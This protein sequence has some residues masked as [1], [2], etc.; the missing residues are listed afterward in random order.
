M[1]AL[2]EFIVRLLSP[3]PKKGEKLVMPFV[4][5]DQ[6]GISKVRKS[7]NK[8][9]VIAPVQPLPGQIPFETGLDYTPG[10]LSQVKKLV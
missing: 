4:T 2:S 7:S 8:E 9:P 5:K 10:D 3:K 1:N 6:T